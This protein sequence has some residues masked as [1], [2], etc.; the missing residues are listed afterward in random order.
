MLDSPMTQ[1]TASHWGIYEVDPSGP[2]PRLKP[3]SGDADPSEIGLHQLDEDI[4]RLRVTRP[5]VRRSWLEHGPGAAPELR[6]KDPFVEIDW[7]EVLDLVACEIAR[8]RGA[9]GNNAI[10]GGSYGWSSAG[11]FH[12]AQSQVH[13]FLNACGGYVRHMDSY[14]LGAA[15]VLMPH[16]VATMETLQAS[17]TSWDVMAAQTELFVTFGGVPAKNAQI[18]SG[19]AGRHLVRDGLRSM[20]E[21]GVR[22]VNVGPVRDNLDTGGAVQWLPVRPNTD[23]ALMMAL[24]WVLRHEDLLDRSFLGRYCVGF[25]QVE[26]YLTGET[27]GVAK[28]PEW[29]AAIT[30]A[31]AAAIVTLA[32]DMAASRTMLNIAWSLQRAAGG[33]QPYWML[34]TLAAMLG[35]IGLPGGGFGV[36]YGA[37]NQIGSPHAHLPGPTLPQGENA[38]EDFIPVARIADMLLHPRHALHL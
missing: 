9:H 2:A 7:P 4:M 12:H 29:A 19:G 27:D 21:A 17:H 14:S 30:G 26:A 22:F 31:P 16:I 13:R 6:G 28:T 35:Q 18:S 5:A 33:E 11:R 8:V 34:V 24:A 10:F 25:R 38:V 32:R 15:R 36:G 37:T 1:Y 20:A 3:F 23:T